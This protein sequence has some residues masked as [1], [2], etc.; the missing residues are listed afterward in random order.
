LAEETAAYLDLALATAEASEQ[1]RAQLLNL[2]RGEEYLM[3]N[4]RRQLRIFTNDLKKR[5]REASAEGFGAL[6]AQLL[7][8]LEEDFD[9]GTSS[10]RYNLARTSEAYQDWAV[11][12]FTRELSGQ[13]LKGE[14]LV[15]PFRDEAAL[16]LAQMVRAIQDRLGAAIEKALGIRFAG[17]AFEATPAP[18]QTPD[19]RIDRTFDTPLELIWFLIPMPLVRWLVMRR[20]RSHLGWEVEKNLARLSGQWAE[21]TS[22]TIDGL[23][24][25]ALGFVEDELHSIQGMLR[26]TGSSHKPKIE[27]A[28]AQ[29]RLTGLLRVGA[30]GESR[31]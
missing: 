3:V 13:S 27:E 9:K 20:L 2:V 11:T 6:H 16:Q 17:T 1:A 18:V 21:A 30:E 22:L 12:A 8:A 31:G 26:G 4:W 5:T 28:L 23:A 14:R 15:R 7:Q 25:E 29:L 10:W 24:S 19:I